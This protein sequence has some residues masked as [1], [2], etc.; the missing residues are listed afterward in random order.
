[1]HVFINFDLNG[2]IIAGDEMGGKSPNKSILT[3]ILESYATSSPEAFVVALNA[4]QVQ[5]LLEAKLGVGI[6]VSQII[7]DN[8]AKFNHA[9][10]YDNF[11]VLLEH[12][13]K[14]A[15]VSI[16]LNDLLKYFLETEK[17]PDKTVTSMVM[18]KVLAHEAVASD[19]QKTV[20]DFHKHIDE[21]NIL[22]SFYTFIKSI[23]N[24]TYTHITLNTFGNEGHKVAEKVKPILACTAAII[25]EELANEQDKSKQAEFIF[26]AATTSRL[27]MQ[28]SNFQQYDSNGRVNRHGKIFPV[29]TGKRGLYVF[30]DDNLSFNGLDQKGCVN[31]FDVSTLQNLDF[32]T[33]TKFTAENES[34]DI[35][36]VVHGKAVIVLVRARLSKT[37][38]DSYFV[39][40][41][42]KYK[43]L[44]ETYYQQNNLNL[45]HEL[46]ANQLFSPK[47]IPN[48]VWD[49]CK[50]HTLLDFF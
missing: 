12:A 38:V 31:I 8:L 37:C 14:Q 28:Q 50:S 10:F 42:D 41:V 5:L 25:V 2:T 3:D 30:Y 40:I 15:G 39:D 24:D 1:M 7:L 22:K 20:G 36:A 21:A 18:Q 4:Q 47:E 23:K 19:I 9:N 27:I 29:H 11:K 34:P 17:T 6:D 35:N 32:T 49:Q 44:A 46:D 16:K 45:E 33:G 13:I 26:K 43:K 48:E